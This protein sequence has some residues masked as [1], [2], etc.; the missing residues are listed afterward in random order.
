MSKRV[1]VCDDSKLT[2]RMIAESLTEDGWEIVA[3][4]KNGQE[5]ID[6]YK[7]FQPDAVTLDLVMAGS[8]GMV[9]LEGI[10]AFD[11]DAKIVIVSSLAKAKVITEAVRKGAIDYVA[12][13]FVPDQLRESMAGCLQEIPLHG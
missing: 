10:R 8:D 6:L 11:P 9:G 7:E 4:A 3:E 5:A 12:K 13:P 1:L 2:R